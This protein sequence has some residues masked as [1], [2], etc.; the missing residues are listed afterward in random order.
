L[1]KGII[2]DNSSYLDNNKKMAAKISSWEKER[3]K[4]QKEIR[5]LE[6]EL[7]TKEKIRG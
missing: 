4:I 7:E 3:A 6:G 1:D 2:K 5:K